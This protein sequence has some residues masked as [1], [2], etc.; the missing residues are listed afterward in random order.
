M[1]VSFVFYINVYLLSFVYNNFVVV[2]SFTFS[3]SALILRCFNSI[4]F[5]FTFID[6][7]ERRRED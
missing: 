4:S 6:E 7:K 5:N 1:S 2:D 3:I